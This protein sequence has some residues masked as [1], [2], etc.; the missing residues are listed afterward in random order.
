MV[1]KVAILYIGMLLAAT[2]ALLFLRQVAAILLIAFVASDPILNGA[3]NGLIAAPA[4][5]YASPACCW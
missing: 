4:W 1:A 5:C 3:Y 2:G